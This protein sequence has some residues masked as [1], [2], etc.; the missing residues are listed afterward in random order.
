MLVTI[1]PITLIL[2]DCCANWE[3]VFVVMVVVVTVAAAAAKLVPNVLRAKIKS[4]ICRLWLV[5]SQPWA[6]QVTYSE[7][8]LA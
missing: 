6:Q 7:L 1:R 4:A 5:Q 2:P 3:D 8:A